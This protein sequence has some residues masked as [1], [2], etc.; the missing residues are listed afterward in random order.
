MI[1]ERDIR[2]LCAL[3]RYYVLART[4]IQ[5][6]CFPDVQTGRAVRRRLQVL[7]RAGLISRI[8][9]PVFNPG[10]GSAWP[11]YFLSRQGVEFLAQHFDDSGFLAIPTRSPEPFHLLHWIDISETHILLDQAI[12]RQNTVRLEGWFSEWDT[13]NPKEDAP[14][15]RYRL[16]ALLRDRPRLVCV[17]DAAFLLARGEHRK[18]FYLEQDRATTGTHQVAARKTPGYFELSKRNGHMR[19]FSQATAPSFTVILIAPTARRRDGLRKATG[20]KPGAHLW[21]FAAK[22][23]LTPESFL[24]EPV[25]FPCE[26]DPVPL[27]KP[28]RGVPVAEDMNRRKSTQTTNSQQPTHTADTPQHT[29]T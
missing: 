15:R 5:R 27:V 16:Y 21:K 10:G 28:I 11:A 25:F 9:T 12:A 18:V 7:V 6:L 17:P 3:A 23:D 24:H 2:I 13:V 20:G 26:G 8:R 29:Q 22:P 1:T 19:H 14:E 4:Q